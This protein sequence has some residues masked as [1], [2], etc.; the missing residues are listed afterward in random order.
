MRA[1][2]VLMELADEIETGGI[3]RLRQGD[4]SSDVVQEFVEAY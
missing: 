3:N 4:F 1:E 2:R